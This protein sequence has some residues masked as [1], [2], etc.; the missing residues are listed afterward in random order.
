MI[1]EAECQHKSSPFRSLPPVP[2]LLLRSPE[3]QLKKSIQQRIAA[4]KPFQHELS[5]MI[6]KQHYRLDNLLHRL[7]KSLQELSAAS[8]IHPHRARQPRSGTRPGQESRTYG[9]IV[10]ATGKKKAGLNSSKRSDFALTPAAGARSGEGSNKV[11]VLHTE[12]GPFVEA[13]PVDH[14]GIY[15]RKSAPADSDLHGHSRSDDGKTQEYLCLQVYLTDDEFKTVTKLRQRRTLEDGSHGRSSSHYT[16]VSD[17]ESLL[18]I[19]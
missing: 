19:R 2:L 1:S 15:F 11:G 14:P 12:Y 6:K 5:L 3:L 18:E 9:G 8:T 13:S 17:G 4:L 16:S 10:T 7:E